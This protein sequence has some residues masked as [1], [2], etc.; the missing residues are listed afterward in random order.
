M[1]EFLKSGVEYGCGCNGQKIVFQLI[2]L[3]SS[4]AKA[5][6]LLCEVNKAFYKTSSSCTPSPLSVRELLNIFF[7]TK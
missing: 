4:G 7:F 3:P 1:W 6:F 5:P 2:I